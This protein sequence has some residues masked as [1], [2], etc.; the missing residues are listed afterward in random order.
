LAAIA[1]A[2]RI[3]DIVAQMIDVIEWCERL[4]TLNG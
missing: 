4:L 2:S 3:G 1:A